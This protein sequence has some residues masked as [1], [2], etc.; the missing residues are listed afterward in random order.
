MTN[1]T[2]DGQNKRN[3]SRIL[4]PPG[5]Q[6]SDIFGQGD[7]P[8]GQMMGQGQ[9]QDFGSKV[10]RR[11]QKWREENTSSEE[12]RQNDLKIK[13]N[14]EE[15]LYDQDNNE[16]LTRSDDRANNRNKNTRSQI[17]F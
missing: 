12:L 10:Q 8:Q 3:N 1:N 17:T 16:Q 4:A 11:E 13:K 2:M 7:L 15:K 14:A 9:A 5:G 6:S